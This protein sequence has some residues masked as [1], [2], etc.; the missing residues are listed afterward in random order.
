MP[1][2][3]FYAQ[4]SQKKNNKN[5]KGKTK[6]NGVNKDNELVLE[7]YFVLLFWRQWQLILFI[8]LIFKNTKYINKYVYVL[9]FFFYT[10]RRKETKYGCADT[11]NW[12]KS[13]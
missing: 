7:K 13:L 3:W 5:L 2:Q 12:F 1:N 11:V 4:I 10:N 8:Q 9:K 6:T